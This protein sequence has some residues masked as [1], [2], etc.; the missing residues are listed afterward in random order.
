VIQ[1]ISLVEDEIEISLNPKSMRSYYQRLI[2][3]GYTSEQAGNLIAKLLGLAIVS[4]G[5]TLKEL[6]SLI[7]LQKI[8]TRIS[9]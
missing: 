6:N 3:H 1:L 9:S 2:T 8:N 4:R 7:F 5:W